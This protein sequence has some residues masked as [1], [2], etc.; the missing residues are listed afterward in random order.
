MLGGGLEE[1]IDGPN[2]WK[3]R[4]RN[5]M[6]ATEGALGTCPTAANR[7]LG[8]ASRRRSYVLVLVSLLQRR[9]SLAA[10][11]GCSLP[12]F[13]FLVA[14]SFPFHWYER[15]S[16]TRI[17]SLRST[18]RFLGCPAPSTQTW[19][20]TKDTRWT[21]AMA[22]GSERATVHV[23]HAL[24]EQIERLKA[25]VRM[26]RKRTRRKEQTEGTKTRETESAEKVERTQGDQNRAWEK[27]ATGTHPNER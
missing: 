20:G 8:F 22:E 17:P 7:R 3:A 19:S 13:F 27:K 12:F 16:E 9:N 14:P 10:I 6:R 4:L 18:V 23:M 11:D 1:A 15:K 26:E 5:R 2:S 21:T 25:E 24:E